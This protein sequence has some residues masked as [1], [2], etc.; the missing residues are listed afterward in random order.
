MAK[1][2]QAQGVGQVFLCKKAQACTYE[3]EGR[4]K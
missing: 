3:K 1:T 2:N 4:K